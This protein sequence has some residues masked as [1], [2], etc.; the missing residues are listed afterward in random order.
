[1]YEFSFNKT[2]LKRGTGLLS[3]KFGGGGSTEH[4]LGTFLHAAAAYLWLE[5]KQPKQKQVPTA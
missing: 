4:I 5:E 1:M 3:F 2:F